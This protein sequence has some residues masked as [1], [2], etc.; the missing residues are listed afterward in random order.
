MASRSLHF[1]LL[2]SAL[3]FVGQG[4][5]LVAQSGD[6]PRL[7]SVVRLSPT[8][9][10]GT[11]EGLPSHRARG[12]LYAEPPPPPEGFNRLEPEE[13]QLGAPVLEDGFIIP[14]EQSVE[15]G[16]A[17]PKEQADA[18]GTFVVL[19]NS[20]INPNNGSISSVNEPSVGSQ[21]DGIFTTFNWYSAIST[22]NGTSVSYV[23]PY[24]TFPNSP[25]AF[26]AGFCCDQRAAQDSSRNLVF[27]FLQYIK[28][29]STSSS[30]NGVRVAVAHGQAGLAANSWTYYDFTPAN[31]SLPAGTWL[32]FPHLQVSANYLY[33][34]S[35][36]FNTAGDSYFGALIARLPLSQ[37]DSGSPLTFNFFT[38]VGSYGSIMPVNGAGAEGTRPGRTTMHFASVFSS[39]SLRVLTWPESS[40]SITVSSVSG[41]ASSGTSAFTCPGPGGL[42]P[43][44]RA[45]LRMQ[46]GWITDTELGLMWNSSQNGA[47]RPYPY[48]RAVLLNPTTLAVLSQPD[49][50]STTNAWLYPAISVN[51]RGHLGGTVDFLGG[52]QFPSIGAIIRDDFSPSL[53]TSGWEAYS[54]VAGTSGTAGRYGD[55]NGSV[56]HEKYP[57][58]WLAAGHRQVGGSSDS[59]SVTHNYWFGRER[60]NPAPVTCS[61]FSINP[62]GASPSSA[63]GSQSVTIT[64]SPAG[65]QG[66]SWSASGNG[67]WLTVSPT[68][69]TGSGSVTVS[70]AQNTSLTSR[71]SAATI[72]GNSFA[73][74]Q[75]GSTPSTCTSFSIN[76]TSANPSSASGSQSVT[77]TGSPAGCTGGSWSASGNGS[78]L[79]VSP[80]SGTGSG[81]VTV[82]WGQNTSPSSRSSSANLASNTFA[83]NQAAGAGV[84]LPRAP[85][86]F[87]GDGVSDW[88]VYRSGTWLYFGPCAHPLNETG[89]ALNP[90]C[91]RCVSTVCTVDSFCC[92]TTW[93]STCIGEAVS[94]CP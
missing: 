65:C 94:L 24:T 89:S 11:V 56:A 32:D 38:V 62:T 31:F 58:T 83:V 82:F 36:I 5:R 86:D 77:I 12:P 16:T 8:E 41:L 52:N 15:T 73:V 53:T 10:M 85:A 19:R 7:V 84:P 35:N 88:V 64:G 80:T 9:T 22:N 26:S 92:A 28:T 60:D 51:E 23:S 25:S 90:A 66:G 59:N 93:D 1:L 30:T 81:S 17:T 72:A 20:A 63:S 54:I 79:T 42:D 48:V 13:E 27:W 43:C 57:K 75:A 45:S 6:G 49:I 37:L 33:F 69:G 78:W 55:Y 44:T 68:S 21:G 87:D 91:S 18:P 74:N 4:S 39:T 34:T 70:W 76:P 67:S 29:G 3:A 61:S 47:S 46:T 2:G 50:F 71:S 40:T 14:P